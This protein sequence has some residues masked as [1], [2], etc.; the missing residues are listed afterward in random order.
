MTEVEWAGCSDVKAMLRFLR[1]KCGV[2]KVRL[3]AVACHRRAWDCLDGNARAAVEE[4]ERLAEDRPA[5]EGLGLRA[6]KADAD[7]ARSAAWRVV[8]ARNPEPTVQAALLRCICGPLPFRSMRFDLAWQTPVV[9]AL[10][11]GIYEDR[12]FDDMPVLGDALEEAGCHNTDI[13]RHCRQQSA[14]HARGCWCLD[15]VLDKE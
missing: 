14:V 15:L 1:F 12:R 13:L 4:A 10:A 8:E 2:R 3:F 11:R 5:I 6:S 7:G 9:L